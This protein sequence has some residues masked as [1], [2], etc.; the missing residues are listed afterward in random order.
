MKNGIVLNKA[1]Y[2]IDEPIL[3]TLSLDK[4]PEG[5]TSVAIYQL[6]NQI[7]VTYFKEWIHLE[8]SKYILQV[9]LDSPGI[10]NYGIMVTVG[11]FTFEGAFDVVKAHK[12][13][14]RYGFLSDFSSQEIDTLDVDYIK[15]LHLNTVQFYDWMYKHDELISKKN[16]YLDPLGRPT[17]LETIKKKIEKC[18]EYG[19]RPF[20][21]GA[22]YASSKELFE[23]HPMWG[24]Y[25]ED[26][27]PLVFFDWLNFMNISEESG[28][29]D[30]I[31]HQFSESVKRLKFMG[32]HMDTY[33][34]PKNVHDA[35]GKNFSLADKFPQLIDR[36][37]L[38][39]QKINPDN[40]VIFNCVNNWPVEKVACAKQDAVY[41]EVWP[42]HDTYYDLYRLI[43]EARLLSSNQVVLAAYMHPFKEALTDSDID[44]AENALLLANA[45]INASGGTQLVFGE[46]EGILQDSYYANYA[47]SRE[48]IKLKI[49]NYSDYLVRYADL[50]YKDEGMDI[51]MTA[52]SGINEDIQF[53]S[54]Q[55]VFSP[56]GK[57][58]SVWTMVREQQ[59]R[60]TIQFLNLSTNN[61]LWNHPK[62]KN[63]EID[64]IWI[65]INLDRKIKGVFCASPDNSLKAVELEAIEE[66]TSRGKRFN[67]LV[68]S[69]LNWSTVWIEME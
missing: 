56:N 25:T 1:Q 29:S 30:Y 39:V 7:E 47:L 34:F 49:Q 32:I 21:Y 13:C 50:L 11:D 69:L 16:D 35:F 20:A 8:N 54:N 37:S 64:D 62:N 66:K 6:Y 65:K 41:I 10:G 59:N 5:E 48:S 26:G 53:H 61:S 36:A 12:E 27:R 28:W 15:D 9:R 2:L 42:P 40:G 52:T 3:F 17:S 44:R 23:K 38:E 24:L 14:I 58:Y 46:L 19:I 60:I 55:V 45:V 4:L 57:E 51:S 33:G 18:L 31:I 68:P 63:T 43:R 22:V 67:I